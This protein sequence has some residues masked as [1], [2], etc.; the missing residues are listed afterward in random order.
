MNQ[1]WIYGQTNKRV[2]SGSA[3]LMHFVRARY[4]EVGL[5]G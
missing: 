4:A 2:S 5:M 1:Q 3:A